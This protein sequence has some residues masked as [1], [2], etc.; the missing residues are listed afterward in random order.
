MNNISLTPNTYRYIGQ[1]GLL[2]KIDAS[3]GPE[4]PHGVTSYWLV[5]SNGYHG[6]ERFSNEVVEDLDNGKFDK[7]SVEGIEYYLVPE[8]SSNL[9]GRL[10]HYAQLTGVAELQNPPGGGV[11]RVLETLEDTAEATVAPDAVAKYVEDNDSY[12]EARNKVSAE[13]DRVNRQIT[14]SPAREP[15]EGKLVTTDDAPQDSASETKQ[16][17]V[18]PVKSKDSNVS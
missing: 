14:K 9:P 3:T 7:A 8:E 18:S 5:P 17:K 1:L 2:R 16:T 15:G 6:S 11:N 10:S 13:D 12:E 4:G